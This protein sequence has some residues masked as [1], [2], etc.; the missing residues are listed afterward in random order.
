MDRS[1]HA[2]VIRIV[3]RWRDVVTSTLLS[4]TDP[5]TPVTAADV[6]SPQEVLCSLAVLV[7]KHDMLVAVVRTA[8]RVEASYF[9]AAVHADELILLKIAVT[10][11]SLTSQCL[12]LSVQVVR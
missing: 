12:V 9:A 11:R 6:A 3:G 2:I 5:C 7:V 10:P 1:V 8:S 4:I